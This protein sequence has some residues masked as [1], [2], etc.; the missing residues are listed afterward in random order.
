M[1]AYNGAGGGAHYFKSGVLDFIDFLTSC[2]LLTFHL[3][4][5]T[6]ART[7]NSLPSCPNVADYFFVIQ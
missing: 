6:L 7:T 4:F 2:N 3:N 1:Y 5:P